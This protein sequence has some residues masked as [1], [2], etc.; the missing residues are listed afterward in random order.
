MLEDAHYG[1]Y[2]LDMVG[3]PRRNEKKQESQH[4]RA[5]SIHKLL[6]GFEYDS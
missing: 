6:Y 2:I 5:V 3:I 1:L 4:L